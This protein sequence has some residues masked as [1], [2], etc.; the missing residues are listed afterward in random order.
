MRRV[1]IDFVPRRAVPW[2][3]WL[4]FAAG[5]LLAVQLVIDLRALQVDVEIAEGRVAR[6][7]ERAGGPRFSDPRLARANADEL[8][9][10]RFVTRQLTLPWGNLFDAVEG[11]ST[12]EVALIALQPDPARNAFRITAET[13]NADQALAFVRRL[14]ATRRLHNVHLASHEVRSGSSARPFR[15]IVI[16]AFGA[17]ADS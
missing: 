15:F 4:V 17:G 11:A 7:R 9:K 5:V 16:G 3:G 6:L 14:E 2:A 13:R 12:K 1:E 8:R 10:A